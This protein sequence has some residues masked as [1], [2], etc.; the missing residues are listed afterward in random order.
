MP[1]PYAERLGFGK[2]ALSDAELKIIPGDATWAS[3]SRGGLSTLR[4]TLDQVVSQSPEAGQGLE[5]FKQMTGVD[6]KVDV[7][8]V[9][10]DTFGYY[11]SDA[12]GGGSSVRWWRC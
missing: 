9:L 7:L 3:M 6:L 8:D 5:Q 10:G 12:T 11:A 4:R 1:R 2:E